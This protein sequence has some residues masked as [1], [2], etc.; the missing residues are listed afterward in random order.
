MVICNYL[1][2]DNAEPLHSHIN[3]Y[4]LPTGKMY[5]TSE[6]STNPSINRGRVQRGRWIYVQVPH[7]PTQALLET[8]SCTPTIY[9]LDNVSSYQMYVMYWD[10]TTA[11]GV[12]TY[13]F[14]DI[15][16][17]VGQQPQGNG[18]IPLVD[19]EAW[20]G[21][22]NSFDVIFSCQNRTKENT[23]ISTRIHSVKWTDPMAMG[24][25]CIHTISEA[26][27]RTLVRARNPFLETISVESF[28]LDVEQEVFDRLLRQNQT[29]SST[30]DMYV[31]G[32]RRPLQT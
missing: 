12:C 26:F 14:N 31:L 30:L 3:C 17:V 4:Y 15:N 28:P 20:E 29:A 19:I 10:S 11:Y 7:L 24:E 8:T 18:F 22:Y 32:A 2:V 23:F 6:F 1:N 13:D 9:S 21:N 16:A 25:G 5:S 27:M